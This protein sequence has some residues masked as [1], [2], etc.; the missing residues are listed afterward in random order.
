VP[1]PG[2]S[3]HWSQPTLVST[4]TRILRAR[5]RTGCLH[6]LW[7]AAGMHVHTGEV[8]DASQPTHWQSLL[9]LRGALPCCL[10]Q[11]PAGVS[12]ASARTP[13]QVLCQRVTAKVSLKCESWCQLSA[14][15]ISKT[16]TAS[17]QEVFCWGNQYHRIKEC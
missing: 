5:A 1:G 13:Q 10:P 2:P 3:L 7:D 6:A 14:Q 17:D 8:G 16:T 12:A 11:R 15:A 4:Q 9:S